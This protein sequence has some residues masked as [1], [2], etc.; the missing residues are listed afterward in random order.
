MPA[1]PKTTVQFDLSGVFTV[2]I[3]ND[4]IPPNL[5]D[6]PALAGIWTFDFG[7]DGVFTVTRFDVGQ[8]VSGTFAVGDTTVTFNE[9]NGLVGCTI[10]A[11][12]GG[13][14]YSWKMTES[15]LTLT[16]IRDGCA[17]RLTL[18]TTRPL[19]SDQAC[20]GSTEPVTG[21]ATGDT[22]VPGTPNAEVPPVSGVTA[23]EGLSEAAET[24]KAVDGLLARAN[25]CWA[26]GDPQS[27]LAL[28]SDAVIQE[29]VFTA[30]PDVIVSQLR[31]SMMAPA[32]FERIGDVNVYGSDR[33]WAYVAFTIDDEPAAVRVDFVN[34]HGSWLFDTYIPSAA[35]STSAFTVPS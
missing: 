13:A 35:S 25:G 5:A 14:I 3:G 15:A 27:F 8:V 33:A 7:S 1:P 11:T 2:T 21:P 32:S 28:H 17:E 31:E 29:L 16:P 18:L 12:D 9:W 6:G 34:E 4:D 26:T 10:G 22:R 30:P 19:G 20:A 23:Q 24:E